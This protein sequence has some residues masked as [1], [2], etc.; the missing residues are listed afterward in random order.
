MKDAPGVVPSFEV[1]ESLTKP[2]VRVNATRPDTNKF[3]DMGFGEEKQET[4]VEALQRQLAEMTAAR[5]ADK[6]KAGTKEKSTKKVKLSKVAGKGTESGAAQVAEKV[7]A[8]NALLE[9]AADHLGQDSID[10]VMDIFDH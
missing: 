5:D 10:M 3:Y 8:V 4:E 2:A 7:G 1:F 6:K 9:D